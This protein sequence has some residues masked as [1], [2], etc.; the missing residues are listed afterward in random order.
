MSQ[1]TERSLIVSPLASWCM[2]MRLRS[3]ST[4]RMDMCGCS[5]TWRTWHSYTAKHARPARSKMCCGVSVAY[6]S[7]A[8]CFSQRIQPVQYV[9]VPLPAR[10]GMG[11]Q[12]AIGFLDR[13]SFCLQVG[14]GVDVG[15]VQADMPHPVLNDGG[16]DTRG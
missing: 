3:R 8:A 13:L 7:P 1:P 5:P 6:S 14:L 11:P 15:R 9:G 12:Y 10:S 16:V 2:R 4:G